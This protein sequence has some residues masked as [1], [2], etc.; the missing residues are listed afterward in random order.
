MTGNLQVQAYEPEG[1]LYMAL[2]LSNSKWRLALS[3]GQH[4]RQKSIAAGDLLALDEEL[5]KAKAKWG[6]ESARVVSCYEAGRDGCWLHRELERRGIENLVIDASSIEVSR[7]ARRAKTDR[8]DADGLLSKL[9]G[10]WRGDR[11]V[12]RVVRVPPPEWED[13][14]ELERERGRLLKERTGH[15]NRLTSALVRH[16]LR[17][18]I[19]GAFRARLEGLVLSDGTPLPERVKRELLRELE[20]LELVEAQLKALMGELKRELAEDEA[21]EPVRRLTLLCGIGPIGAW[22]LV[23]ELFGWRG[24]ANRRELSSLC[25]LVPVPYNSGNM[26]RE[27]GISKAGNRRVRAL[28]IERAWLWLR[29]QP[30]SKHSQWFQRRFG[31]GSRRQRRIGIVALARRLVIDLWRYVEHGVLPEGARLKE[32]AAAA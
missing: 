14:R 24:I 10:Y 19:D 5:A 31:G 32:V 1:I 4:R 30:Q 17:V 8:L 28:L 16:G 6:L 15:R 26:V 3:D 29:Y 13:R 22:T 18:A 9:I 2:E 7:R 12:W 11:G 21:L 20:R 25:G 27:Q 23:L